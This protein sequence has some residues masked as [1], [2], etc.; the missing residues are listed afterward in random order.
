M[1]RSCRGCL[2]NDCWRASIEPYALSK[3]IPLGALKLF[4]LFV[5]DVNFPLFRRWFN[6]T[7]QSTGDA[8]CNVQLW[9]EGRHKHCEPLWR[10]RKLQSFKICSCCSLDLLL[11]AALHNRWISGWLNIHRTGYT[12]FHLVII[13]AGGHFSAA[14]FSMPFFYSCIWGT[15]IHLIA[16]RSG[17]YLWTRS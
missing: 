16:Y 1:E 11:F 9:Q 13:A 2:F 17:N 12:F 14:V 6:W 8:V 5:M 15:V 7:I 10:V 3:K 4:M